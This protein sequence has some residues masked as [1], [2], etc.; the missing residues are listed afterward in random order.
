MCARHSE[1]DREKLNLSLLRQLAR[2]DEVIRANERGWKKGPEDERAGSFQLHAKDP[3][4]L[5]LR[6]EVHRITGWG[7]RAPQEPFSQMLLFYR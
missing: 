6:V 7:W 3:I 5:L 2:T 4:S 1:K